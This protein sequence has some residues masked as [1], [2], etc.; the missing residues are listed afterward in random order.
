MAT[1]VRG[2]EKEKKGNESTL[3]MG[4]NSM[5]DIRSFRKYASREP[6]AYP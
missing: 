1:G 4:T 6:M 2:E 3:R 5:E